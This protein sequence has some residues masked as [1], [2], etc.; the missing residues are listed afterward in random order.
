MH[1]YYVHFRYRA[2]TREGYERWRYE[3][4]KRSDL[5]DAI[6]SLGIKGC[7]RFA[8]HRLRSQEP[9]ITWF[10][11]DLDIISE[12]STYDPRKEVFIGSKF[13]KIRKRRR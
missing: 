5:E 8:F 7:D 10:T 4:L 3:T 12:R 1:D 6:Y 13:R 11:S 9:W 2:E